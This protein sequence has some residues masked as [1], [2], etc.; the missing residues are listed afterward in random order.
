[1]TDTWI[2]DDFFHNGA[3]RETYGYEYVTSMESSKEDTSVTFDKDAYDWYLQLGSLSKITEDVK[4]RLPTWI[5]FVAHPNYDDYWKARAAQ[6]YLTETPVA[7]LVVGGWWD[8]RS[9]E[10]RVG[11]ECRSRWS[12]YH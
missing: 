2:G 3:F 8:Q 10:R 5:A 7:T 4:T 9:E 1:M 12:P 11:K 6:R